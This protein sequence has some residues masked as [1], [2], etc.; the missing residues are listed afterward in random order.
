MS[1]LEDAVE[2]SRVSMLGADL[3]VASGEIRPDRARACNAAM[4]DVSWP[5]RPVDPGGPAAVDIT[6]VATC[7]GEVAERAGDAD[8]VVSGRETVGMSAAGP[9]AWS[10]LFVPAET[11]ALAVTV[12]VHYRAEAGVAPMPLPPG[13]CRLGPGSARRSPRSSWPGRRLRAPGGRRRRM[14]CES[15]LPAQRPCSL[16][17]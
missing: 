10:G 6:A 15:G 7:N 12:A 13:S 1:S 17:G 14:P 8:A 16:P 5:C 3:P 11:G 2:L 4:P 9:A